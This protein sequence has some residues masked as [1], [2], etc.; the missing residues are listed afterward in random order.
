MDKN[1]IIN[2]EINGLK[3]SQVFKGESCEV[4]LV[5]LEKEATFPRHSSPKNTMI[6]V[7]EGHINLYISNKKIALEQHEI[8]EFKKEVEHYVIAVKDSKFLIIR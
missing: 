4:K 6:L 8:F 3:L 7:L 1:L 5:A 2:A